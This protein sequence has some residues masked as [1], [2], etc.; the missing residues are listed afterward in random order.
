[1]YILNIDH[2]YMYRNWRKIFVVV[3]KKH[4]AIIKEKTNI[5]I[6]F[7]MVNVE[8]SIKKVNA[9]TIQKTDLLS[10]II[11]FKATKNEKLL[12]NIHFSFNI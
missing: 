12:K 1:M 9:V 3:K 11:M 7:L 8:K 4:H 5:L 10:A 6:L 2:Q